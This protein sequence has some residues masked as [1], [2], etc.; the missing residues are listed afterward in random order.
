MDVSLAQP[1][2]T[3]EMIDEVT[4]VLREEFFLRGETVTAFEDAFAEFVG[5][6]EAI[7]VN[8]GTDALI[9]GLEALGV[10]EGDAVITTPGTFISTANAIVAVDAEPVFVDVGLNTY[11]IDVDGV[12]RVAEQ[13][14]DIA[15]VIPVHTYGYPVDV[16]AVRE[17][18]GGVPVLADACQAH[19]ATIRGERTGS[20]ADVGAFSFYPSKNMTVA[21]DGGMVTTDD[22]DVA[23][24]V[25]S[26]R[27]VGRGEGETE[28]PRLG[29]TRR[30]NTINAA[31]GKEQ[32][33]H[34][35]EW[36]ER[37][38]EV[39]RAYTR[40]LEGVGDL[41]LPPVPGDN[42]QSAWYLYVVR[43]EHRDELQSFLEEEGVEAGVHYRTPVHLHPPY[44]DRGHEP[45]EFPAAERW[46][47]EVLSLPIHPQLAD[48]EVEYV[49]E[50]VERFFA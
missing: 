20:V 24:M 10:G 21:G 43:T 29:F 23:E 22:P 1:A 25:R 50:S 8:S 3:S 45:G 19:G 28:H 9:L 46:A 11:T 17:A 6:E 42:R 31:V 39:A 41:V 26:L 16:D 15:A 2:M 36:N 47:S 40:G 12:R 48:E 35:D 32:L 4:R 33:R 27:D 37:R 5:T 38:R 13:R 44:R 34:L 18:A 30:M 14:D 49:V 7:A